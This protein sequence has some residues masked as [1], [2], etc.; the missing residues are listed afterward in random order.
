MGETLT[1][2]TA[3]MAAIG[4]AVGKGLAPA[5]AAL[6][7]QADDAMRLKAL[8]GEKHTLPSGIP[9][10]GRYAHGPTGLLT[11]PGVDPTIFNAMVGTMGMSN[12]LP[13]SPSIFTNPLFDI[14]T[15][16]T[17]ESGDEPVDVCDD[18]PVAGL[19]KICTQTSVFGRY[20]RMTPE[21]DLGRFGQRVNRGDPIDLTVAG[22]PIQ[23]GFNSFLNPATVAGVSPTQA[24]TGEMNKIL[25]EFAVN[26]Q[27]VLA[28]QVWNGNPANN[29]AGQGRKEMTGLNLLIG[30]GKRDAETGVACPAADSDVKDFNYLCV[31]DAGDDLV[32]AITY[33]YRTLRKNA[34]TMGL[35]P[36]RWVIA[37]RE[38]LFYELTAIYPCSYL[39]YRCDS[40]L[41]GINTSATTLNIDSAEA[42]RFRDA[43]RSGKFL[44]IDGIDVEVVFDDA[45]TEENPANQGNLGPG[46]FASNIYFIPMSVLG[47]RASTFFEYFNF[48]NPDATAARNTLAPDGSFS[49]SN[50]GAWLWH[51][52]PPR[53]RCL[54][55]QAWIEPRLIMRTPYLAGVLQNVCYTPLQHTRQPFPDDP[56]FTDGGQTGPRPG[57][58]FF[59]E[60][61]S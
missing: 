58:S 11:L 45:I 26:I 33:I 50:G 57:P 12:I 13:S 55:A 25:F 36:V 60:W 54:Q 10:V 3:Q 20:A 43:M 21:I 41:A 51:F 7:P 40:V 39:T 18:A 61:Q 47:G 17:D 38:E 24:V 42:I 16:Q 6:A 23:E 52:K 9:A 14:L 1:L 56:Y 44:T 49:T 4:E 30:T 59:N 48:D 34:D 22:G 31:D 32:N 37:M 19:I 28:P 15:G 35:Q 46:Q 53:N 8:W 29:N 27:R 5:I 2:D